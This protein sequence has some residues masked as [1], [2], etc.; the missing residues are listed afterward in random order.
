[1]TWSANSL[2]TQSIETM[3]HSL[4]EKPI[5]VVPNL[6]AEFAWGTQQEQLQN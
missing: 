2:K 1:M 6:Q 3:W 4:K 5:I